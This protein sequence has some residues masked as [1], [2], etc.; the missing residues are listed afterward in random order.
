MQ[1]IVDTSNPISR[2]AVES[3][4]SRVVAGR[5]R[6]I[7]PLGTGGMGDVYLAD[8]LVLARRVALKTVRSELCGNDEVRRRILRECRMQAAI[9]A[10]PNI[11][12]LYDTVEEDERIYLVME[13][14]AGDTLAR[15]LAVRAESDATGLCIEE[16]V[17]IVL[18]ILAALAAIHA[19]DI[20]HRDIKTSNIL[21]RKV[22]DGRYAVK[23]MD[24][25]IARIETEKEDTDILTRVGIRGPGTPAYM[26]PERIDPQA[27]G[28]ISPA[29]DLYSVG[30]ILHEL[31]RGEPPFKG[32]TTKIFTAHLL[33][34]PDLSW[35]SPQLP[36]RIREV[37]RRALEKKPEDRYRDAGTF[38]VDLELAACGDGPETETLRPAEPEATL[39]AADEGAEV[40]VSL[41]AATILAPIAEKDAVGRLVRP[42]KA[43]VLAVVLACLLAVFFGLRRQVRV[44]GPEQSDQVAQVM[45]EKPVS[46]TEPSLPADSHGSREEMSALETVENARQGWKEGVTLPGRTENASRAASEWQVLESNSRKIQ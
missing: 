37:L 33:Q 1:T 18:Q 31:L 36:P 16:I 2:T 22:E 35:F 3:V 38:A 26:A 4:E 15:L 43:A 19:T 7:R 30:V 17:R 9:G 45:R 32:S 29:T 8:D 23:L 10:H 13:Y 40:P 41:P 27:F 44:N 34:Q 39:L 6:C 21:L 12:T 11:I 24:F 46:R 5:Y 28:E 42:G 20:V 14:F 25:G